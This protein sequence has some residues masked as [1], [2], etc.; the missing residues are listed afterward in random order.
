MRALKSISFLTSLSLVKSLEL[1]SFIRQFAKAQRSNPDS[2][3]K[4]EILNFANPVPGEID[5]YATISFTTFAEGENFSCG[6]SSVCSKII[7]ISKGKKD[8][9]EL[10][11]KFQKPNRKSITNT[12]LSPAS[13]DNILE[14]MKQIYDGEAFKGSDDKTKSFVLIETIDH[15]LYALGCRDRA[16]NEFTIL[17]VKL[18]GEEY[19]PTENLYVLRF[20][21]IMNSKLSFKIVPCDKTKLYKD[22]L[23]SNSGF[24]L[25]ILPDNNEKEKSNPNIS[26][27]E[28]SE[29]PTE[30]N[31]ENSLYDV[32]G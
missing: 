31:T 1:N 15:R 21:S 14:N 3:P 13:Y 4:G 2:T 16:K 17:Q 24:D 7:H 18:D 6:F 22:Y 5:E 28:K 8:N 25:F 11:F 12:R 32:I 30:T 20:E 27:A 29:N 19:I 9:K 23:L 10:K 26:D